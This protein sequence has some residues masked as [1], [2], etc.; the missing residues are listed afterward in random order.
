MAIKLEINANVTGA[1]Q[2]DNLNKSLNQI[3]SSTSIADRALRTFNNSAERGRQTIENFGNAV[4]I[5]AAAGFGFAAYETY[6]FAKSI[7]NV[8]L[9]TQTFKTRLES[10]F[11]TV[12]E[13]ARAFNYINQYAQKTPYSISQISAAFN[14]LR[15]ISN[16][17]AEL[18]TNLEIAGRIASRY[19][20]PFE[21]AAD[22]LQKSFTSGIE[23]SR[24]F[25]DLQI[26]NALGLQ[27]GVDLPL[28]QV[29]E[30]FQNT[31][32]NGGRLSGSVD[33]FK[34]T[35]AGQVAQIE[36]SFNKVKQAAG[37]VVIEG[38]T[39]QVTRLQKEFGYSNDQLE[40]FGRALGGKILEGFKELEKG[41]RLVIENFDKIVAVIGIFLALDVANKVLGI[42]AAFTSFGATI[43]QVTGL[44]KLFN[45]AWAF[46]PIGTLAVVITGIVAAF[47][48]WRKEIEKFIE[49]LDVGLDKLK[50]FVNAI[51][52]KLGGKDVF[53]VVKEQADKARESI[54]ELGK[55]VEESLGGTTDIKIETPADTQVN[56]IPSDTITRDQKDIIPKTTIDTATQ[57]RKIFD[58]LNI[59][60]RR[61]GDTISDSWLR[62]MR[63]GDG[64]MKSILGSAK[65]LLNS[66]IEQIIRQTIQLG[67]E[68]VF[69]Q[70]SEKRKQANKEITEGIKEQTNA[71]LSLSNIWS[72]LTGIFSDIGSSISNVFSSSGDFFSNIGNIFSGSGG[73]G[74]F[75]LSTVTDFFTFNKGGVVPGGAPYTDRVPALLTPGETVIPRGESGTGGGQS[76]TTY[77]TQNLN[78][79]DLNTA[80]ISAIRTNAE[81][82]NSILQS[83]RNK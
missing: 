17:P 24:R 9:E 40:E 46:S 56:K 78:T 70:L 38:L 58:Q 35:L 20:I 15:A 59:D 74:G 73:G 52:R 53:S 72:N 80:L 62:G 45:L 28:Y 30:A 11:K 2:V 29:R 1:A 83:E 39:Q 55:T 36:N 33:V 23:S 54:E 82:V 4:R 7:V 19:Q 49:V 69:D 43:A 34:N 44:V 57:L 10:S 51:S 42:F 48:I 81:T 5:A 71:S 65:A 68:K 50:I 37:A 22:G 75:D 31:F 25:K 64:L 47:V 66:I 32:S 63:E 60:S 12:A 27:K 67:V 26:Q 8:G 16:T 79:N 14:D 21:E 77:I 41:I 3:G 6:K 18:A 76:Y 13:G 61:I